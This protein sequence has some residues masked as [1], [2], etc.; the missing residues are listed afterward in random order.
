MMIYVIFPPLYNIFF[1]S[2]LFIFMEIN[3]AFGQSERSAVKF[4]KDLLRIL[5]GTQKKKL[6]YIRYFAIPVFVLNELYCSI[7]DNKSAI[8]IYVEIFVFTE[9]LKSNLINIDE[10]N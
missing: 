3:G 8:F 2:L 4:W 9:P 6:R 1:R 7:C 5:P 10:S